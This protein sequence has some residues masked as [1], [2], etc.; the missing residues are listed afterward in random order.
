MSRFSKS[1]AEARGWAF[2]HSVEA[3]E[4]VTSGTQGEVRRTPES[5]VAEK[6]FD[7]PSGIGSKQ[8]I[9][10]EGETIGKLLE[11]IAWQEARFDALSDVNAEPV[12]IERNPINVDVA[13]LPLRT[14]TVPV[15]PEDISID[16]PVMQISEEEWA[17]RDRADVLIVRGED[18]E[19]KQVIHGGS[20]P[21]AT[22]AYDLKL[23]HDAA[24]ENA[25]TALPDVDAERLDLDPA[26]LIDSPG[27]TGTGSLLVLAG[28]DDLSEV[29]ARKQEGKNELENQ[30]AVIQAEVGPQGV[31]PEGEEDLVGTDAQVARHTDVESEQPRMT[32]DEFEAQQAANAVRGHDALVSGPTAVTAEQE[33]Q[34][35]SE[36][37]EAVAKQARDTDLASAD[38]DE[39]Q[40]EVREAGIEATE[41]AQARAAERG[42]DVEQV[43]GTGKDGRVTKGDVESHVVATPAA[44]AAAEEKGI[45]LSEVK[46]TGKEG[47]VTKPDV[48]AADETRSEQSRNVG[49]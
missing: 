44:E 9:H 42:V 47:K 49:G 45:D 1:E 37:Q 17:A 4:V 39:K 30:R 23:L 20:T 10:E 36:A 31:A 7:P 48:E 29:Q 19:K 41:A 35:R 22:E 38:S 15:D 24:V 6:Y 21:E 8:L 32:Q 14:V 40:A 2:V 13:G 26:H 5:H 25:R 18:G 34:D 16:K 28:E 46:G 11:R 3:D 43:E 27:A 33:Q 12:G